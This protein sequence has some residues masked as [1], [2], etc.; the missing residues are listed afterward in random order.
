[1][2]RFRILLW[3]GMIGVI[4][5][6]TVQ[7][8]GAMY[9]YM[10]DRCTHLREYRYFN[11]YNN[12]HFF[13]QFVLSE[14]WNG[15]EPY[16]RLYSQEDDIE[17]RIDKSQTQACMY[18]LGKS[19]QFNIGGFINTKA[20][21]YLSDLTG[22]G[23]P[24]FIYEEPVGAAEGS[25]GNCV[26]IDLHEMKQ[27]QIQKDSEVLLQNI[28]VEQIEMD[29]RGSIYKVTDSNHHIYMGNVTGTN[30]NAF[31][32][33]QAGKSHL[34][35]E[36]DVKADKLKAYTCFT[37]PGCKEK[38]YLGDICTYYVYDAMSHQFILD[39]DY[40]VSLWDPLME[41]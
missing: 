10:C 28:T 6:A 21:L 36:Y 41:P 24:E 11:S 26:V 34:A 39:K 31:A 25:F 13:N 32:M 4:C 16:Y 20:N 9:S 23:S 37:L 35:V 17:V 38:E 15:G 27:L 29:D 19:V 5:S 22:D 12:N 7:I 8:Q 18:Y 1:M 30:P 40:T 2:K 3:I 14:V 33:S